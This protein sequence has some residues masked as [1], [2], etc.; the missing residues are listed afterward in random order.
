MM[1]CVE[2]ADRYLLVTFSKLVASVSSDNAAAVPRTS[3]TKS[4]NFCSLRKTKGSV[5]EASKVVFFVDC[6]QSEICAA[7]LARACTQ[8]TLMTP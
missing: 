4:M 6:V 7:G 5:S 8:L 1:S 2:D 3:Y